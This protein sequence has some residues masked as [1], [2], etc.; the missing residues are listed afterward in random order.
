MLRFHNSPQWN[1]LQMGIIIAS[2]TYLNMNRPGFVPGV[3]CRT[4]GSV[5]AW[6]IGRIDSDPS[7]YINAVKAHALTA[8]LLGHTIAR[9]L[10]DAGWLL[11]MRPD[12]I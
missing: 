10:D 11:H 2:R 5:G 8:F 7:L 6:R 12:M 4:G 1:T 9:V 3:C